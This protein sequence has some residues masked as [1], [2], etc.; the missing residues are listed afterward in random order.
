MFIFRL[1]AYDRNCNFQFQTTDQST[2]ANRETPQ[3][4]VWPKD[5]YQSIAETD[6][7]PQTTEKHVENYFIMRYERE[8]IVG[9]VK[10]IE[11]G[12][13]MVS[14]FKVKACS[15][16][17]IGTDVFFS[18]I[19]AAEMKRHVLYNVKARMARDGVI[20]NAGCECPGGKGPTGSC[21][22]LA[23]L[24]LMV[25]KLHGRLFIDESCTEK[26]QTFHRPQKLYKGKR[27]FHNIE[28]P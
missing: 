9:D 5:G 15:A 4:F 18:G 6:F 25:A 3:S 21:K 10:A 27:A 28:R 7:L 16:L 23:A 22:H 2:S 12:K 13:A 17:N 26:L 11:K 19:V 8:S 1:S 24:C 14:A 20:L